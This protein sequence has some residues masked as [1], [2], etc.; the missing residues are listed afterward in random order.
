[1]PRMRSAVDRKLRQSRHPQLEVRW[2]TDVKRCPVLAF[3]DIPITLVNVRF[4][5]RDE[6]RQS[7]PKYCDGISQNKQN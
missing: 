3:A 2:C 6:T 4:V 1:M 5:M 7:L